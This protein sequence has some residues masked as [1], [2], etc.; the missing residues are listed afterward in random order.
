MHPD[1]EKL[2]SRGKIEP[3]TADQLDLLPPVLSANIKVGEPAKLPNGI[4]SM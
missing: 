1:L 2:V 4:G 3:A